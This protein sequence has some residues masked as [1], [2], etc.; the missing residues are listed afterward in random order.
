M[1]HRVIWIAICMAVSSQQ[2]WAGERHLVVLV[3][4][5]GD[6]DYR[7]RMTQAVEQ[8]AAAA[9]TMLGVKSQN[10]HL[11][12]SDEEM[13]GQLK[14]DLPSKA[15]CTADN[16]R[17]FF[18]EHSRTWSSDDSAWL[19]MIGHTQLTETRCQF[20]VQGRDFTAEDLAG[21]MKPLPCREQVNIL[22]MP[23]SGT[24]LLPLKAPGR[25][26]IAA[27]DQNGETTG[28]EFPYALANI[29]AGKQS[30][31]S[32][33]DLDKDGQRSLLDLYLAVTLEVHSF[34]KDIERLPTEHAQLDDNGDG[35]GREVQDPLI[36]PEPEEG[37][38][39]PSPAPTRALVITENSDGALARSISLRVN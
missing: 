13:L 39:P 11:L 15:V 23:A 24:W 2:A 8:I 25:V 9:P 3:G 7:G 16:V 27:T 31:Q 20:N 28:T 33:D 10:C 26:N 14:P 32:L 22:T 21:W 30:F 35:K 29:L 38:D 6:G 37:D 18:A 5:T 34:Y 17:T 1:F 12:V 19:V 4:L 36:P